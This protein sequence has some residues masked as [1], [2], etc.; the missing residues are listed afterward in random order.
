MMSRTAEIKL[1]VDLDADNLPTRIEWYA[2]EG[3]ENGPAVCQS[4]MLSLWDSEKKTTAAIDLWIKD[5]T[6]EDMNLY[7]YQ[8]IHKMADTYLRATKNADMAK[9]IRE[10]GDGFGESLGLVGRGTT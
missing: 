2:S 4:M 10:F 7:F 1:T 3:Q 9:S 5:T 6:V 8:V